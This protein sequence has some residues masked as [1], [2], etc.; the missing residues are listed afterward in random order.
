LL[1]VP[2]RVMNVL[3]VI[4]AKGHNHLKYFTIDNENDIRVHA[5]AQEADAVANAERFSTS[6]GLSK[7]AD[8]WSA[9]RLVEVWN[10][11]PGASSIKK[12]TDRRTASTRIWKAIQSLGETPAAK[13]EAVPAEL[14][15]TKLTPETIEAA[16]PAS[17]Q[18]DP[19]VVEAAPASQPGTPIVSP[20]TQKEAAV[21]PGAAE[22]PVSLVATVETVTNAG[23]QGADVA[24]TPRVATKKVTPA[25]KAPTGE[26]K[27]KAVREGSKTDL[28]IA[29]MKRPGGATL[30]ELTEAF[31][32]QAHT[33][34][35][36]MAGAMKKAGIEVES[37]K[38]RQDHLAKSVS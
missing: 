1:T 21:E 34:R 18:P 3:T 10:S 4:T 38:A 22:E 14:P 9:T 25:K 12:F 11:L 16:V 37:F 30:T 5:S 15:G 7:L 8:T 35:G 23:T 33:V 13:S 28:A 20:E 27:L 6:A 2:T 29:M 26:T 36:F 17:F 32:W 19:Q 31:G 24:P